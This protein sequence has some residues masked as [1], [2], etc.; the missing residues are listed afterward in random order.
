MNHISW[1]VALVVALALAAALASPSAL[2]SKGGSGP[3]SSEAGQRSSDFS[4]D[5]GFAATGAGRI[6]GEQAAKRLG[7]TMPCCG[8]ATVC[9]ST[10]TTRSRGIWPYGRAVHLYT[11]WCALGGT[12]NYR[13]SSA[14]TGVD[15]LCGSSNLWWGKVGGGAG[16][17]F[18]DVQAQAE[19]S[20]DSPF[21]FDW[22]DFLMQ[23]I[24]YHGNGY[25][26]T[27]GYQ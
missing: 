21:W 19:F 12:I 2:A 1:R 15:V 26:E 16:W 23:R 8:D 6:V 10:T 5:P 27:I 9:W 14:W 24:R 25:Y 4:Y 18:V 13:Y 3:S 17:S 11:L 20:C 7:P 22:H